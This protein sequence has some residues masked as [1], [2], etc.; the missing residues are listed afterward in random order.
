MNNTILN[1]NNTDHRAI[2]L[3]QL[4]EQPF[5]YDLNLKVWVAYSYKYCKALLLDENACVPEPVIDDNGPMNDKVRLL[6]RRLARISNNGQHLA[7]REAAMTIFQSINA[8]SV[9][10][11]LE[12]LLN[13]ADTDGGFDWVEVVGKQLP[14]LVILKGLGFNDD[15]GAYITANL[16][17]LVRVMLPNK[18][19]EDIEAINPTVN[20]IYAIAERYIISSGLSDGQPVKTE[21]IICNLI[22]LFIQCYDA[23]RGLLCNAL[24]SLA[25]QHN[26]QQPNKNDI[27]FYKNLA[28]ETLRWDPP[29]HYTRRVA[30]RDICMGGEIIGAGET[31]QIVLAAANLDPDVFKDP[32]KFDLT[33]SNN[34]QHL[35]FGLGG[36]NCIAKY[37]SIGM[38]ANTCRFLE[39]N[40]Q[41]INILQKEFSYES[42]LNVRLVKQLMVN[43]S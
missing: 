5:Y 16:A 35:T 37:L 17:T 10:Q 25:R 24:L 7:S 19:V 28:T 27:A 40:Y 32:D 20:R 22:G 42:Q 4:K 23:G 31:I 14:I 29:G 39:N 3:R 18:T 9:D 12:R 6:L 2:Y 21:L 41:S 30:V 8:V 13:G 36:H 1:W 43:L 15:D 33:R 11:V 26:K 38:A 34:E